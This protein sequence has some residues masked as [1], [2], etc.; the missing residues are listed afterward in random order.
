MP[1]SLPGICPECGHVMRWWRQP[2]N[3]Y[4]FLCAPCDIEQVLTAR[5]IEAIARQA[6]RDRKLA[7]RNALAR[8]PALF[9]G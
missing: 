9:D 8:Q 2:G 4:L 5:G 7:E 6:E 1:N 3:A